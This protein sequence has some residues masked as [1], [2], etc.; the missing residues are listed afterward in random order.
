MRSRSLIAGVALLA[1]ASVAAAG[2]SGPEASVAVAAP[3]DAVPYLFRDEFT[4][5]DRA[6]MDLFGG[7]RGGVD[8]MGDVIVIAA[9]HD[10]TPVT[11]AGAVY[12]FY[13]TP[14]GWKQQKLV[15]PSPES[16]G[17]FGR[18]V[19]LGASSPY[20]EQPD[21][22]AIGAWREGG[23]KVHLYQ[24]SS[25]GRWQYH[26]TVSGCCEFGIEVAMS[27]R[28][29]V[30][31]TRY[32]D[33][34]DVFV[35]NAS[36]VWELQ[37]SLTPP[38][39]GGFAHFGTAVAARVGDES[40]WIAVGDYAIGAV[41]L[42]ERSGDTWT[43]RQRLD[44]PP[45]SY[46]FG[47]SL[48]LNDW[49]LAVGAPR[50][51]YPDQRGA[52]Y[53]YENVGGTWAFSA[54]LTPP[55]LPS[56]SYF[57]ADVDLSWGNRVAV[58]APQAEIGYPTG[59]AGEVFVF[60]SADTSWDLIDRVRAP[61][62]RVGDGFGEGVDIDQGVQ[63]VAGAPY[64]DDGRG[65]AYR[66]WEVWPYGH[67]SRRVF[68]VTSRP[69]PLPPADQVL[70]DRLRVNH[71]EVVLVDDDASVPAGARWSRGS[72]TCSMISASR[73]DERVIRARRRRRTPSS[74]R[75]RR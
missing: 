47:A 73:P 1:L 56:A 70:V 25:N 36:G 9:M 32:A 61:D 27:G 7:Y 11:G 44:G 31:G 39:P 72:P 46:R 8:A 29:L 51:G 34:A 10:D 22:L 17:M 62:G 3:S 71:Y 60:A 20:A 63:L 35:E 23:G 43:F 40:G 74:S 2:P 58:G 49:L 41:Y 66:Y 45:G 24:L 65:A 21:R 6:P 75:R 69:S 53:M 28:T 16:D 33:R 37:A 5:P 64:R 12:S 13:R 19:V 55:D 54:D 4:V 15:S 52:A 67:P 48:D 42:F 14:L 26:S 59:G 68:F 18:S 50:T 30:V 57:G 38:E